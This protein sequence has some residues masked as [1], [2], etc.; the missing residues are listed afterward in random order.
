MEQEMASKMEK[1]KYG[2]K[3]LYDIASTMEAV[4]TKSGDT[5]H[6]FSKQYVY[7]IYKYKIYSCL[8]W[9]VYVHISANE[10]A[11]LHR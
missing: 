11:N 3:I 7:I 1:V 4:K 5:V 6:S 10:K 8:Y 2:K 9:I